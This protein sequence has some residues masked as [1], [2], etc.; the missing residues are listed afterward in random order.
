MKYENELP[1]FATEAHYLHLPHQCVNFL[2]DG[3]DYNVSLGSFNI[4]LAVNEICFD[5]TI[6][7]D[8]FPENEEEFSLILTA[9]NALS[10][11]SHNVTTIRIQD[12]D[13]RFS[14]AKLQCVD[15]DSHIRRAGGCYWWKV[16]YCKQTTTKVVKVKNI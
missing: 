16:I 15:C 6:V 14:L 13:G 9:D 1:F 8:F 12:N 7:D 10:V 5:V 4:S 2:T 11:I 3:L